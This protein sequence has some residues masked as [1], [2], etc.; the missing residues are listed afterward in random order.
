MRY[1]TKMER[2]CWR[3]AQRANRRGTDFRVFLSDQLRKRDGLGSG[4]RKARKSLLADIRAANVLARRVAR[5]GS[6]VYE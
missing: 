6:T 3:G 5:L 1:L 4:M 2:S